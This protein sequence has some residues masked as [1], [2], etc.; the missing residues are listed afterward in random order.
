[1]PYRVGIGSIQDRTVEKWMRHVSFFSS[2]R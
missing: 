1:V 2:P